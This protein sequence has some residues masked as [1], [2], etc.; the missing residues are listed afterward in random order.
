IGVL[1]GILS[2][3]LGIGGGVVTIPCLLIV[4]RWIGII[5]SEMMHLA[6]GT[7]LAAMV[8]STLSSSYYHKK[9]KAI[10][11]KIVKPMGIGVIFGAVLGAFITNLLPSNFLQV[12]FGGFECLLGVR[13]LFPKLMPY[14]ERPLPSSRILAGISLIVA[15]L[16]TMLGIGGGLINVPILTAFSVPVKRAIGTSS[17]LSFLI[18]VC[19]AVA[20][21]LFG[22]KSSPITDAVGFI[23]L[24]AFILISVFAFLFAPLGVKWA[25]DL[26]INVLKR[27]FGV[28]LL[29]AGISIIL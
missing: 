26:P 21:L 27:I 6:I 8:F 28:V 25:H 11:F 15:T 2:G 12:F 10:D 18:A 19:G 7:S 9:K 16:S 5:P 13:F 20:F 4:F 24:P 17:A 22:V 23:Y 14:K 1:A 3:L 29:I